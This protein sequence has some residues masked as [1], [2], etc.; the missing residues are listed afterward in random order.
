MIRY[1]DYHVLHSTNSGT[2]TG[3]CDVSGENICCQDARRASLAGQ[4]FDSSSLVRSAS[5]AKSH[6]TAP[7]TPT[8]RRGRLVMQGTIS[9]ELLS[10]AK[11]PQRCCKI[12]STQRPQTGS[13]TEG[14][15][16]LKACFRREILVYRVHSLELPSLIRPRL[17]D[18]TK[19]Y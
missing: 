4:T 3:A 17:F 18:S 11:L 13:R 5:A 1:A 19:R 2:V 8:S 6:V 14:K 10:R 12:C 15:W 9:G 7:K 16:L